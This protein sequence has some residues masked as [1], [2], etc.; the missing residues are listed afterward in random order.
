M[1]AGLSAARP[2]GRKGGHKPKLTTQQICHARKLL[3]GSPAS[4]VNSAP[5]GPPCSWRGAGV[6]FSSDLPTIFRPGPPR[7]EVR[8]CAASRRPRIAIPTIF[9]AGAIALLLR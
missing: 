7:I 3:A 6:F 5:P 2:R 1:L 4:G 9:G 8:S